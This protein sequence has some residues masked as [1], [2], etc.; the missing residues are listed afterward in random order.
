MVVV[1]GDNSGLIICVWHAINSLISIPW[2]YV[3]ACWNWDSFS[4]GRGLPFRSNKTYTHHILGYVIHG[5][6]PSLYL[7]LTNTCI[8][9][10]CVLSLLNDFK[11]HYLETEMER[12]ASQYAHFHISFSSN[13]IAPADNR[14]SSMSL[15]ILFDKFN[16]MPGFAS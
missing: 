2:G 14:F 7:Q 15:N 10:E 12:C 6:S 5:N 16:L 1:N 8:S 9:P 4:L 11:V 13:E 3:L